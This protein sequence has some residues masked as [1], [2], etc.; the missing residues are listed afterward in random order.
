MIQRIQTIYLFLASLSMLLLFF[1][2]LSSYLSD[3]E[4]YKLYVYGLTDM[5]PQNQKVSFLAFL[6]LIVLV[7]AISG[8]LVYTVFKYKNRRLQMQL[9]N[10]ALFLNVGFIAVVFFI[11]DSMLSKQI[12][13]RPDYEPGLFMPLI[14]IVFVLLSY[15]R[16]KKD[17]ELVRSADRLR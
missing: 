8:I 14:S 11:Y 15:W 17:D 5:S 2:P 12:A 9:L 4:Y 16:I 7:V 10:V 13:T 3:F 6:P 1:F